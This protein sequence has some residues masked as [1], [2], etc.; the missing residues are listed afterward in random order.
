MQSLTLISKIIIVYLKPEY[1]AIVAGMEEHLIL[2]LVCTENMS[3]FSVCLIPYFDVFWRVFQD[4]PTN[5][6]NP[7]IQIL[8]CYPSMFSIEEVGRIC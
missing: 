4:I 5:P 8:I 7:N 6:L 1:Q 2:R 3:V